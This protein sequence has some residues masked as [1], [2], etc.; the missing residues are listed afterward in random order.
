MPGNPDNS[1]LALDALANA[2]RDLF[3]AATAKLAPPLPVIPH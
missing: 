2:E 1:A 3:T